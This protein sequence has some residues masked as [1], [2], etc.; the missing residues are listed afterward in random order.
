MIKAVATV[1]QNVT[2]GRPETRGDEQ[3]QPVHRLGGTSPVVVIN[4]AAKNDCI[5]CPWGHPT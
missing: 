5:L 3:P 2:L 1:L 4:T